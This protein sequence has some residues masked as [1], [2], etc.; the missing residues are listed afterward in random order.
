MEKV[1]SVMLVLLNGV[2]AYLIN[3]LPAKDEL[4]SS[5]IPNSLIFW[6]TGA[7]FALII[8]LT[9]KANSSSSTGT[10]TNGNWLSSLLPLIGA[11]I[12]FGLLK[13][14]HLPEQFNQGLF[15]TSLGLFIVGVFLPVL[16]LA[17]GIWPTNQTLFLRISYWVLMGVGVFGVLGFSFKAQWGLVILCLFGTITLILSP[18]LQKLIKNIHQRVTPYYQAWLENLLDKIASKFEFG[19]WEKISSFENKYSKSLIDKLSSYKVEGFRI[20]LP[21]LELEDVF[22]SLQ[23]VTEIPDKVSGS[24]IQPKINH[25]SHEIWNFLAKIKDF[26]AYRCLAILGA[27]GSGKTTL[28]KYLTLTYAKKNHKKYNVPKFTPVFL[29]LRDL[30]HQIITQPPPNLADLIKEQIEKLPASS[31]LIPPKNWIEEELKQSLVMLD[32][33][34]EVADETE[35]DAVSQWV[36]SQMKTYSKTAFIITSRPHGYTY[37][38]Q[39]GTVLQ[40]LPFNIQQVRQF[41]KSWYLHTEIRSHAKDNPAVRQDAQQNAEKLIEKIIYNR[42]I[43]DMATNPLLV[44]MIATVHYCGS[45]LPGRRVELYEKI[46]SLLLGA[47]QEAKKIQ[48]PLTAKQNQAVLQVL[49]LA[50]MQKQKRTFTLSEGEAIIKQ[51]LAQVAGNRLTPHDFLEKEIKRISGLLIERDLGN[52]E[53]VHLSFQ[54]YLAAVQVKDLQQD[55]L[56]TDNIH[57]PWWAE[58]I[59]LYAAQANATTLIEKALE[60]H[61]VA[62]LCLA[63]DCRKEG[64]RVK[65]TV[66]QRLDDILERGLESDDAIIAKLAAEVKL[67]RRLNNLL[68]IKET[69]AIDTGYISQAEYFIFAQ[70]KQNNTSGDFQPSQARHPKT[71]INLTDALAFCAWLTDRALASQTPVYYRLP[72]IN[73]CQSYPPKGQISLNSW[74]VGNPLTS[75]PTPLL[76]GEGSNSLPQ[77]LEYGIRVVEAQLPSEYVILAGYLATSDWQKA[78]RETT[79]ILRQATNDGVLDAA[80]L[81]NLPR[82]TLCIL[83]FLWL[84]YSGGRFGIGIQLSI[85]KILKG[86]PLPKYFPR[87]FYSQNPNSRTNMFSALDELFVKCRIERSLLRFNFEIVTVNRPGNITQQQTGQACYFIEDLGQNTFLEMVDIPGGTFMMGSSD[88]DN[89][90]PQHQVTVSPFFMSKYPITQQQ[91][92]AVASLPK[93]KRELHLD[94]SYFKGDNR[95]VEKISW[96]D[97]VEFCQRL[98]SKTGRDYQLPSEAQWE[99]AFDISVA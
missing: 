30:R 2:L 42:A 33:L 43:A 41:I 64:L 38:E 49:A 14:A 34:D 50:L 98:S 81:A 60:N 7:C 23:V 27:P 99:Y 44:T 78:D 71:D 8:W 79:A 96:L 32:G 15:Y 72:T 83:D 1:V 94:P 82:E 31:P 55:T 92:K 24:M 47:R 77:V 3:Q 70:V 53:F 37:L 36:N 74:T 25:E 17:Q 13:F 11:V 46:C 80:A 63:Y 62:S 56:L 26:D 19:L 54:E 58:T 28:L 59:R 97:A 91:W 95:P 93:V 29:Y 73:E 18:I 66:G 9:L 21:V 68:K 35:R 87:N 48:R 88:N 86:K 12:L 75:P 76:Q 61:T 4:L 89:E 45:A 52:Y 16:V 67:S 90:K 22:I 57:D 10:T 40:V 84:S 5:D 39:V 6:L 69:L 85:W 65:P 51:E 20:G